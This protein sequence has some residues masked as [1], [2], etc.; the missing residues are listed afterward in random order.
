MKIKT[1]FVT[2]SSSTSFILITSNDFGKDEYLKLIGIEN[3]SV[4]SFL[5]EGLYKVVKSKIELFN[6]YKKDDS[7][8][9]NEY[10][11]LPESIKTKISDAES[12]NKK[13]YI[14]K[15]ASEGEIEERFFCMDSFCV[16]NDSI[17]FN[18]IP[19]TW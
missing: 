5:F 6:N 13:V 14:G 10:E 3:D 8:Q 18:A 4:F 7:W 12:S 19:N 1:D 17:Y 16:E 15:L 2:N 11:Y 9:K